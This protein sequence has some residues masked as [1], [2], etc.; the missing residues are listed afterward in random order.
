AQFAVEEQIDL[1]LI[2]LHRPH[3]ELLDPFVAT[4]LI[5]R[6]ARVGPFL[7]S[8]HRVAYVGEQHIAVVLHDI[9]LPTRWPPDFVYRRAKRP[10]GG[11]AS[12]PH[13]NPRA[14]LDL[15]VHEL[16]FVLCNKAP[17]RKIDVLAIPPSRS[18]RTVVGIR[19]MLSPC[20]DDQQPVSAEGVLWLIP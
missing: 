19:L 8:I 16:V 18:V 5:D 11:P 13:V 10:E 6:F 17:R 1:L 12:R 3:V 14:H 7:L 2:P 15:T 4:E 9:Y 20:F